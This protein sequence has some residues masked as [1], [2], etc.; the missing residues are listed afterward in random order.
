M[1]SGLVRDI[2]IEIGSQAQVA[3]VPIKRGL[4]FRACFAIPGITTSP[5]FRESPEARKR[6]APFEDCCAFAVCGVDTSAKAI[7]IA[8]KTLRLIIIA[9]PLAFLVH[10]TGSSSP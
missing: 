3:Q 9:K 7:A 10:A 6:Q 4:I 1:C 2:L 8:N 5:Q